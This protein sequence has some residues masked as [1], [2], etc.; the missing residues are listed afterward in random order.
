MEHRAAGRVPDA[1]GAGVATRHQPRAAGVEGDGGDRVSVARP[2]PG[3][4]LDVGDRVPQPGPAVA[5]A[6]QE[7]EAV[8]A[9]DG[10]ADGGIEGSQGGGA[11]AQAGRG[12]EP[13]RRGP[14]APGQQPSRVGAVGQAADRVQL[15]GG[16]AQELT[17]GRVPQL[18]AGARPVP[19]LRAASG[20][21]Q[22]PPVGADRRGLD[23][24]ST[25]RRPLARPGAGPAR[26]PRGRTSSTI[27][28]PQRS[29]SGVGA[30]R[31]RK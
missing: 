6:Q 9:E 30:R 27:A 5:A 8:A 28:T 31:R 3:I 26:Q 1:N 25:P 17:A 4:D 13:G 15:I 22:V 18:D 12:P 11:I 2:V 10:L 21:R 20:D 7:A 14:G 24:W 29:R 19:G 16:L 23:R